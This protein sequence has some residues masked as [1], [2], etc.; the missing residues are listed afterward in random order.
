MEDQGQTIFAWTVP[1][2]T[3]YTRSKTWYIVAGIVAVLLL[4]YSVMTGNLLFGII[5][6][7]A[8]I[9]IYYLDNNKPVEVDIIITDK[10][11]IVDDKYHLFLEISNF[12]IIHEPPEVDNLFIEFNNILRPR[13]SIALSGQN[14]GEIKEFLKKHL[15]ENMEKQGEPITEALGRFFKL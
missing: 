1:E 11:L 15:R 3:D 13:I 4:V 10:G 9:T 8:A 12:Y 5:I 14:H 2:Y 6:L 7:I